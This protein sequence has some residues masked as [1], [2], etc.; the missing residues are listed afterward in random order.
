MDVEARDGDGEVGGV[1][2]GAEDQTRGFNLEFIWEIG[3]FDADGPLVLGRLYTQLAFWRCF[4]TMQETYL[5]QTRSGDEATAALDLLHLKKPIRE[6]ANHVRS[7]VQVTCLVL[8]QFGES[9]ERVGLGC[10]LDDRSKGLYAGSVRLE[11]PDLGVAAR[12]S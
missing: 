5:A 7:I 6:A 11:Q 1:G 8:L 12:V 4:S 3:A 2:A 10:L 9:R